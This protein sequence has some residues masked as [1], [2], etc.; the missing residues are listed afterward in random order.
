MKN[1]TIIF[2]FNRTLF[3]PEKNN[4]FDGALEVLKYFHTQSFE[5]ILLGKGDSKRKENV[6]RLDIEKY[7]SEIHIVEEKSLS[8]LEKIKENRKENSIY[9]IGDRIKKE[10]KLGNQIGFT[11]IWFKNGKFSEEFPNTQEEEPSCTINSLL[12]LKTLLT[13]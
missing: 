3:D 6:K 12:E 13:R 11:T 1:I 5:L 8:Q 7:F 10:I 2:D 4:L 9:S